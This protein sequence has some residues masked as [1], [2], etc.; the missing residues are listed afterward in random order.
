[1]FQPSHFS[2]W[3]F[4]EKMQ[5]R[6][7]SRF[8]SF[9][10][11]PPIEKKNSTKIHPK[12]KKT[13]NPTRW[14]AVQRCPV[15]YGSPRTAAAGSSPSPRT[16]AG[17][18]FLNPASWAQRRSDSDE[19]AMVNLPRPPNG[20]SNPVR[21]KGFLWQKSLENTRKVRK[22]LFF[23]FFFQY[24]VVDPTHLKICASWIGSCN[25]KFGV[26]KIQKNSQF[27]NQI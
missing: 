11:A 13:L 22:Q 14:P 18:G 2:S 25:P 3:K 21:N 1:M 9:F 12:K 5:F 15:R 19:N 20:V 16:T 26:E 23:F 7:A 27:N 10:I 24:L 8:L 17:Q 6:C 4:Q